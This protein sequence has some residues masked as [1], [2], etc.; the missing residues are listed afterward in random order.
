M[1]LRNY[2]VALSIFHVRLLVYVLYDKP[3]QLAD[4]QDG[5]YELTSKTSWK[6]VR[7]SWFM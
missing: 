6:V 4:M 2:T 7:L 1:H 5:M 3:A